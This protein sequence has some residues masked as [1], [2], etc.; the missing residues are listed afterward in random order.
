M[1]PVGKSA[2]PLLKKLSL[3][4]STSCACVLVSSSSSSSRMEPCTGVSNVSKRDSRL[5]N[6]EE[7]EVVGKEE[8]GVGTTKGCEDEARFS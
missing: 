5:R 2:G 1:V 8:A 6:L 7:V 3:S 4:V